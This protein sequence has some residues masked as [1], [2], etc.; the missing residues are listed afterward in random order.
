MKIR[1]L[2]VADVTRD[3]P[4]VVYFHEQSPAR[5]QAEVGEYI[6]TGGYP[7][8]DPRARR[9]RSG[10]HEQLVGL[11]RGITHELAKNQGPQLP[12]CWIAG[13]YGS[14]KSSFAKLLGLS[15]D[16]TTLPDGTALSAAFLQRDD[17][18]K[19]QELVD[20]WTELTSKVEAF[21]VV[22][23]IGGVARDGEHIHSAVLR[24]VQKRLSY[25]PTS[26][27]VADHEL[28][29]EQD[30]EWPAFLVAA[31]QALGKDWSVAGR[32]EQAAD[33]F[34]HALSVLKPARYPTPGSWFDERI[35]LSE[36]ARRSVHEAVDAIDRM[37]HFREPNKSLFI[38]VDEVSQYIHQDENR[39]LKLQSFVESLG[40]RL[41]GR[42]WLIATGQQKLEDTAE[43][44]N[45]GKL[46]DRFPAHLRVHLA[47]TN[48]RD[49]VHKRLLKKRADKEAGLRALF[50]AHRGDL[51]VYGFGCEEIT[52]ED[53][54]EV[55]PMLPGHVELLMDIT[56]SL[57]AVSTRIQGDDHAIRGLLQLLS[58]LFQAHRLADL[59]VGGLVTLDAIFDVQESALEGDVQASL[60]RIFNEPKAR[61]DELA[62]R[63]AKAVSLLQLVQ[64]KRPTTPELVAKTLYQQ[65][66]E[67]NRVQAVTEA[68]ERLRALNLVSFAEKDGYKIQS[69]SGQ[70]WERDRNDIP[71]TPEQTSKSVQEAIKYLIGNTQERPRLKGRSF[72]W[73]VL[74]SDG[75]QYTDVRLQDAKADSAVT[76]DF[77]FVRKDE[78]AAETWVRRSAAS[79]KDER[80]IFWIV[81]ETGPLL[82]RARELAKS[83]RMVEKNGGNR[84][85]LPREKQ[86]HLSDEEVRLE[87][88]EAQV[89]AAVAESFFEGTV[90][91]RG[92]ELK[93]RDAGGAFGTALVAIGTRLLPDL[94]PH[95]VDIAISPAE[96][97]QLLQKD[98]AGPSI[99][100]MDQGLGILSL[101]AGKYVATCGGQLPRK[102]EEQ[103]LSQ[104]GVSAATLLTTLVAPPFGY[105]PD[106]VKACVA[107]LLRAK[108][109]RIRPQAGETITSYQDPGVL[110]FFAKDREFRGADFF[111]PTEDPIKPRDRVAIRGLFSQYLG[112]ELE[113][114]DEHIADATFSYF[115]GARERL[116]DLERR[117]EALPGRPALPPPLQQLAKSLELC[118]RSRLV[119]AT[120]RAVRDNLDALRDGLELLGVTASDLTQDAIDRLAAAARV[121]DNELVQLQNLGELDGLEAEVEVLASRLAAERPWKDVAGLDE[122]TTKLRERFAAVRQGLLNRQ[123]VESEA[124]RSRLKARTGFAQLDADGSHRVLRPITDAAVETTPTAVF[125]TLVDLR[126]RHATQL[127]QAEETA[128]DRLDDELSRG[129]QL[130]VVKVDA[131]LKGREV[132]SRTQLAALFAELEERIGPLL[133]KGSRVR[134]V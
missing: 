118:H 97:L 45:L 28:K 106:V 39:M 2:F 100:L 81:G 61:D 123:S 24:L 69:S 62:I 55:Y 48:I 99:K 32:E 16:G 87:H 128:N 63:V 37:I 90:Y 51:K 73:T 85:S 1:E 83:Q 74:F 102:V 124:A 96:I 56:T 15:L 7:E 104:N 21:S 98:L 35:G 20:A 103:I 57:R 70:E 134:I 53:F 4:P 8:G 130:P 129:A 25:C 122:A 54:V 65:L 23:D 86:R 75:R 133:D 58:S 22:F 107:G 33:H 17:S 78:R 109:V 11:L 29:L 84:N 125:P 120:V 72:P 115:P 31:K 132:A 116:R 101:D 3:I 79:E 117:F 14:G 27:A 76:V 5:L 77:R 88:L 59:E 68:L 41:R 91:F 94:Y 110:D 71:V 121:R 64:D 42:V 26:D 92:Q 113:A 12:A 52:E 49:V 36:G 13:F 34:S 18:P 60:S 67:G 10:I 89:R 108:R 43:T 9:I 66:G 119:D 30:G 105:A 95:F 126:D 38:V 6:V 127:S 93:P 112:V 19:R 131:R 114:D 40:A 44:N 82:E 80:T 111:P 47:T 46:K 50:Q